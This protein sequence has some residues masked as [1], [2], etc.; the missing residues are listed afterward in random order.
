MEA[1]SR[2]GLADEALLLLKQA[3]NLGVTLDVRIYNTCIAAC[4]RYVHA[5]AALDLVLPL[6]LVI[7]SS[8]AKALLTVE[9]EPVH[10]W[11]AYQHA[12]SLWDIRYIMCLTARCAMPYAVLSI[13]VTELSSGGKHCHY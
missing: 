3:H 4:A 5:A 2:G 11:A 6:L 13:C 10:V 9:L 7:Q 8:Q 12:R 1:C